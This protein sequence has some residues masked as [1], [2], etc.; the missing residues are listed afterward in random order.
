MSRLKDEV[1]A[2]IRALPEDCSLEDIPYHLYVRAKVQRGMGA[3]ESGAVVTQEEAESHV[4]QG[5]EDFS[6]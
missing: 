6:R 1:I 4:R 3:A 2:L 5:V